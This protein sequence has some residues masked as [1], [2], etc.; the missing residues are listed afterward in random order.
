MTEKE[1]VKK[2]NW[3]GTIMDIVVGM[4]AV[5]LGLIVYEKFVQGKF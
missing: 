2:M 5:V 4:I 1:E 3:K